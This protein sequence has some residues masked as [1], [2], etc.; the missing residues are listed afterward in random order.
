MARQAHRLEIRAQS[1]EK[2][3]LGDDRLETPTFSVEDGD[4]GAIDRLGLWARVRDFSKRLA[5]KKEL[6]GFTAF[7]PAENDPTAM[8]L[9]GLGNRKG[10]HFDPLIRHPTPAR[11]M[12]P[13]AKAPNDVPS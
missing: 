7:Y 2:N 13:Q 6:S 11:L 5:E 1:P 8:R 9:N 3:R 12:H 10:R 4:D